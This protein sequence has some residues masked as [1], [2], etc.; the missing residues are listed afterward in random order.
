V[1]RFLTLI[2]YG[3]AQKIL[4]NTVQPGFQIKT[5]PVPKS[6]G[7]I[8]HEPVFSRLTVP[9]CAVS[10]RDGYAIICSET[11]HATE[12]H[13]VVLT[14]FSFVHTGSPVPEG[15]DAVI[16]QE[17]VIIGDSGD[18]SIIKPARPGQHI[19]KPGSEISTGK[20]II[21]AGHLIHPEDVGGMIGYGITTIQVRKITAGL[22]PTGDELKEPFTAP[23]PGEVIASNNEMIA[24]CLEELGIESILYP[25]VPDDPEKI[26][27]AIE[28]AVRECNVVIVTGG[29]ST[30]RRD[31]TTAVLN[32]IGK[33]L[34]HGIAM[35]PGRTTLAAVVDEKPVFGLPGTPAGAFAVLRELIVPWLSDTGHPIP[36]PHTIQATLAESVPSELGTDDFVQM[37]VGK[38]HPSYQ[39]V[40]IP[41]A[42]GQLSAV[43]SNGILHIAR[44]S[45][46]IKQGKECLVHLTRFFPHPNNILLFSGV[47]DPILDFLNQFLQK[48][49]M[50]LYFRQSA[51]ETI[52]L[53]MQNRHFHGGIIARP[54][55]RK[56]SPC[57]PDLSFLSEKACAI[58][59]ADREYILAARAFPEPSTIKGHTCP[60]LPDNS[61]LHQA[62]EDYFTTQQMETKSINRIE[63]ICRSEQEVIQGIRGGKIDF[64]PCS[65]H[66][67]SEHDLSGPFIG[68]ESIDL[69]IREEDI[70]T[71]QIIHIR[72][73]LSSEE[74]K[75]EVYLISG[76]NSKRSGQM[77]PLK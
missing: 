19:Q 74:W 23:G 65:G 9:C 58:T 31:H 68:S 49:G 42:G 18:I 60:V 11:F 51:T 24:A 2:P 70:E 36:I 13:P 47:S 56:N 30:G 67:A 4:K 34:Y 3:E 35:R 43:K 6:H 25:I 21:P 69:I 40:M 12:S 38:V 77:S 66:L 17:D 37:V 15:Y 45:E 5:V 63:P 7:Y 75:E 64:G 14:S 53:G 55:V 54:N 41:R 27:E 8:S 52:L 50:S 72:E 20:M 46:G 71:E 10:Q 32:T 26:Q 62:M 1:N 57:S 44:N 28:Q 33:I 39:A 76:Y 61:F 29:S 22:I 73:I 59:V 48:Q 16:M